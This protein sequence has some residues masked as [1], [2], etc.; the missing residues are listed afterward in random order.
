MLGSALLPGSSPRSFFSLAF[1]NFLPKPVAV[2]S[3]IFIKFTPWTTWNLIGFYKIKILQKLFRMIRF[4]RSCL[5]LF[6]YFLQF[7]ALFVA[8]RKFLIV[9]C[10]F[11]IQFFAPQPPPARRRLANGVSVKNGAPAGGG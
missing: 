4:V 9:F 2:G 5:R 10:F 7:E 11:A 1:L 8:C 3:L 6:N